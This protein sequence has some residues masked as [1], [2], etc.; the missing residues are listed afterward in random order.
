M[1]NKEFFKGGDYDMKTWKL[2]SGILS[3]VLFA[4]VAFQSCAVG[5]GNTMTDNGEVGGSAGIIVAIL[6]LTG[7]IISIATKNST[8]KGGN[9]ALIVIFA[10]G[11]FLGFALAG[12]YSDLKIWAGWC[13]INVIMAVLSIAKKHKN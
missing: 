5:I 11:A 9:I 8:G 13:L 4:F 1:I 2:V 12:G 3:I 10:I 7:G 6:L